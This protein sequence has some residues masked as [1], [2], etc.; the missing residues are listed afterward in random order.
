MGRW[1]GQTLVVETTG[2]R[3]LRVRG[4]ILTPASRVVERF[5]RAGSRELSYSFEV[6]DPAVYTRPF[7][8][9]MVFRAADHPLYEFACHEG[10]YS[11]PSILAAARQGNQTSQAEK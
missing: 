6:E 1:Q 11:L 7:R 4:M 10:N 9:E 3:F 8:G 5:T 2:F